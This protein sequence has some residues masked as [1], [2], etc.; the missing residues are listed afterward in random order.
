MTG[1]KQDST[2]TEGTVRK[3]PQGRP[4][5]DLPRR[6]GNRH[7]TPQGRLASRIKERREVAGFSVFEAS[8]KS[9]L[10]ISHWYALESGDCEKPSVSTLWAVEAILDLG[11]DSLVSIIWKVR[12]D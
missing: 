4:R 8:R 3:K 5:K 12:K 7:L 11:R 10:S 6:S 2:A 1:K 9:R